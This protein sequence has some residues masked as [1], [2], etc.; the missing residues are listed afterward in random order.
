MFYT[1]IDTTGSYLQYK[2]TNQ[3]FMIRTLY[4]FI[5]ALMCVNVVSAQVSVNSSGGIVT[6]AVYSDLKVAFD[7]INSGY[8]TGV[9]NI[10]ITGNFTQA[11]TAR[12]DSS[13]R[14][15]AWGTSSYTSINIYPSGGAWIISGAV[16]AGSS[17]IHFN[18]A[19]NVTIN[20]LNNGTDSLVVS[21]R[22]QP[23][24]H[25][26]YCFPMTQPII[27]YEE[28]RFWALQS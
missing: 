7:T 23:Q 13:G 1:L 22:R 18:G 10:V 24:E 19:D 4:V 11:T 27:S 21:P 25:A 9:I 16:P 6:S 26:P 28:P 17:L 15:Q 14:V 2:S 5:V 8:Q 12:L 20:G 3:F